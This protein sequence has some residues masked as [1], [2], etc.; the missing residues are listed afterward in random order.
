M[1]GSILKVL[2]QRPILIFFA[3]VMFGYNFVYSQWSFLYPIHISKLVPNNGAGFYG[4]LVSFNAI[5]VI[6]M[7]PIITKFISGK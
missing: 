6:T 2:A 1:E 7:T 5:I 4:I 3:L